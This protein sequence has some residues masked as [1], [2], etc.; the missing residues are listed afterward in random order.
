M[1][2][3][4][5]DGLSRLEGGRED[6]GPLLLLLH[7]LGA[8]KEVWAPFIEVLE[9]RWSGAWMAPD[10][11]GHGASVPCAHDS[12]GVYAAAVANVIP[13]GRKVIVMGHSLGGLVGMLLG[14]GLFGVDVSSVHALSVKVCWTAEE[15]ARICDFSL[16][17]A[18]YFDSKEEA[19]ARYLKVSGLHGLVSETSPSAQAG[20]VAEGGRHRLAALPA[21][22]G[23]AGGDGDVV[24][25]ICK[26][27]VFYATGGAD[28]IAPAEAFDALGLQVHV[29]PA[30][31]HNA[32]VQNPAA[33][34][35]WFLSSCQTRETRS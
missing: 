26:S 25:R 31:A 16:T 12:Y 14:S 24:R 17:P 30:L 13:K 1:R 15:I 23:V 27:P 19:V 6:S 28:P 33:V 3:I 18:K 8:T 11:P 10:F 4:V 21:T 29:L 2:D 34:C 32:H 20:V 35:D 22:N 7:G 9:G 5:R